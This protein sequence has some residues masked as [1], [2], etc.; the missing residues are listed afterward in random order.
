[1]QSAYRER[2]LPNFERLSTVAATMLLAYALARIIQ[3]PVRDLSLQ[4]PGL[5]LTFEINL[6]SIVTLLVAGLTTAGADWLVATIK[7]W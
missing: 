7:T 5:L 3:V 2:Y 1:M 6:R 4:L